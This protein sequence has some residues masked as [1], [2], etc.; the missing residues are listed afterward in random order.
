M[1]NFQTSTQFEDLD[2]FVVVENTP[3]EDLD[4][5]NCAIVGFCIVYRQGK[6]FNTISLPTFI[7]KK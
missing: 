7:S 2:L 5:F 3:F 6:I 1:I 4:F